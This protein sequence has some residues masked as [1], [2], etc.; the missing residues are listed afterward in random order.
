MFCYENTFLAYK[1]SE[2]HPLAIAEWGTLAVDTAPWSAQSLLCKGFG[3]LVHRRRVLSSLL[4]LL[5]IR[6]CVAKPCVHWQYGHCTRETGC[7]YCHE[8]H[9][10]QDKFVKFH[11]RQREWLSATPERALLLLL[12]LGWIILLFSKHMFRQRFHD[13]RYR[14]DSYKGFCLPCCTCIFSQ[15]R[16]PYLR[17]R[18]QNIAGA[19]RS[20]GS[21]W[22]TPRR[23]GIITSCL[24]SSVGIEAG[25]SLISSRKLQQ[26]RPQIAC[27]Y[28]W[29]ALKQHPEQLEPHYCSP[30]ARPHPVQAPKNRNQRSK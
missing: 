17:A 22:G 2:E 14:V 15:S 5:V 11:R 18:A 4:E 6:N 23:I 3:Q 16:L 21:C 19:G 13:S 1:G 26:H 25:T 30:A 7:D 20:G 12:L 8:I 28:I 10:G 29:S 27:F 24:G 9:H